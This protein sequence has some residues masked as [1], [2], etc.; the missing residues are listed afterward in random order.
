MRAERGRAKKLTVAFHF[1]RSGSPARW[2]CDD[3]R[4]QGLERK[5][6]C[7]FLEQPEPGAGPPVWAHGR[8]AA[9]RCPVSLISAESAAWLESFAVWQRGG[10]EVWRMPARDVAAM[11]V[12]EQES[13]TEAERG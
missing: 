7:G 12:L 11:L 3:C 1:I 4:R 6:R 8:V 10:G 9:E 5:R 2:K 13:A